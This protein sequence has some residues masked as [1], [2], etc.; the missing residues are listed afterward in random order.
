MDYLLLQ[1]EAKRE[2][3]NLIVVF[4]AV[5]AIVAAVAAAVIAA[6]LWA[7]LAVLTSFAEPEVATDADHRPLT[8]QLPWTVAYLGAAI[9]VAGVIVWVTRSRERSLRSLGGSGIARMLGGRRIDEHSSNRAERRF[10]NAVSEMAIAARQAAPAVYVLD[11][12][13][14]INVFNAGWTHETTAI[15]I[16]G[17]ALAALERDELQAVAAQA[18][19]HVFHGDARLNLRLMALVTGVAGL[20]MIG[21]DWIEASRPKDHARDEES[22]VLPLMVAG[23]LLYAVGWI[24]VALSNAVQRS[25]ARRH[26][27]LADATAV[28]LLRQSEPLSDALRRVGGHPRRGGLTD[29]RARSMNHLFMVDARRTGRGGVHPDLRLRILRLDP[30]WTGS[31]LEEQVPDV[32]RFPAPHAPDVDARHLGALAPS[33][34]PPIPGLELLAEPLGAAFGGAA[35]PLLSVMAADVMT[36]TPVVDERP[37]PEAARAQLDQIAR[38]AGAD[39]DSVAHGRSTTIAIAADALRATGVG[40]AEFTGVLRPQEDLDHWIVHRLITGHLDGPPELGGKR[41]S[42]ERLKSEFAI[43]LTMLAAIGGGD[44]TINFAVGAAAAGFIGLHPRSSSSISLDRLD[45]ALDKLSRLDHADARRVRGGLEATMRGDGQSK[46]T[47]REFVS[48][49]MLALHE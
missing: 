12:E 4:G 19:S 29:R 23:G 42:L 46:R 40:S 9:F 33:A 36:A 2:N 27:L 32:S 37:S 6:V 8:E 26:E 15:G 47:E 1:D 39:P 13:P 41:R 44:T 31:W 20:A 34:L 49:V 38:D 24:G 45:R 22:V 5:I 35:T 17:G 28:E 3:R 21:E 43:A 48:A 30:A 16:T 18:M 14:G 10:A 11:R 25:V 7:T